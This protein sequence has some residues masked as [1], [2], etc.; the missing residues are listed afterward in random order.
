MCEWW[1]LEMAGIGAEMVELCLYK[2]ME[3]V[4]CHLLSD[5]GMKS[6]SPSI[7]GAAFQAA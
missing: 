3:A 5:C 1:R 2:V 6:H 4:R 7:I